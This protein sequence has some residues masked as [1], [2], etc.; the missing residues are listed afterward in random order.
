MYIGIKDKKKETTIYGL[1]LGVIRILSQC[2]IYLPL[3]LSAFHDHHNVEVMTPVTTLS[4][5]DFTF[6]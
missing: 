3:L 4:N 1:R 5:C 6:S 2:S